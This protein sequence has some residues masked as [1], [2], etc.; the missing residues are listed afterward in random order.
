[1]TIPTANPVPS[2]A[3]V[4]LLFNAE[5]IDE[6]MNSDDEEYIDRFGRTKRT[7]SALESEYPNAQANAD[8]AA[9]SANVAAASA[10]AT[11]VAKDLALAAQANA[12]LARDAAAVNGKVYPTTTAGLAATSGT[13]EANRYFSVP[14]ADTAEYLVLYRNDNG[15]AVAQKRYPSSDAV[16]EISKQAGYA[17]AVQKQYF[18]AISASKSFG[19]SAAPTAGT[20]SSA[21]NWVFGNPIPK[22]TTFKSI[23]AFGGPVGGAMLVRTFTKNGDVFTATGPGFAI[24]LSPNVLNIFPSSLRVNAGE[25]LGISLQADVIAR[26]NS[27]DDMGGFYSGGAIGA[28]SFTD[29]S[30]TNGVSFQIQLEYDDI[31]FSAEDV[32]NLQTSVEEIDALNLDQLAGAVTEITSEKIGRQLPVTTGAGIT[33]AGRYHVLDQAA[34]ENGTLQEVQLFANGACTCVFMLYN[35]VADVLVQ[36]REVARA[37]VVAGANTVPVNAAIKKGQYIGMMTLIGGGTICRTTTTT[38]RVP[39]YSGSTTAINDPIPTTSPSTS[40][41]I[42][43]SYFLEL[44]AV[45]QAAARIQALESEVSDAL[46]GTRPDLS[47]W[48]FFGSSSMWYMQ[49]DVFGL[50]AT[51]FG[52]V[53][54]AKYYGTSASRLEHTTATIGVNKG[55]LMFLDGLIANSG[56]AVA[57]DGFTLGVPTIHAIQ[58]KLENG[59]AGVYQNGY[60]TATPAAALEVNGDLPIRFISGAVAHRN[61]VAL[62]NIGKNNVAATG[63]AT[64]ILEATRAAVDFLDEKNGGRT[65]IVGHFVDLNSLPI[66][67]SNVLTVNKNLRALYYDR[68]VDVHAYL[69]SEQVWIDVGLTKT[70]DDIAAIADGGLPPSLARDAAHLSAAV[71]TQI[72]IKVVAL[73]TSKGWYD[74]P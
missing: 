43:A 71:D 41:R 68:F 19:I 38:D 17:G 36:D 54:T 50:L 4:D 26:I 67:K 51:T 63:G 1:M 2:Q 33:S 5:K 6:F 70:A 23:R 10:G 29:S 69:M 58:G 7:R 64:T 15:T 34:S 61:A 8:A 14:S 59:I 66:N 20:G 30:K 35:K 31:A 37:N 45:I 39:F 11:E 44:H 55:R 42:E 9:E 32:S 18:D 73:V 25:H 48:A 53:K 62:V 3:P 65:I 16:A 46:A 52:E 57:T 49:D 21:G 12:E 47:T 27:A 28:T 56:E 74:K 13:G 60:F 22:T 72:A 40:F 24:S